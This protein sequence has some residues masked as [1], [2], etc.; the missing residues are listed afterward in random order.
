RARSVARGRVGP[1][2]RRPALGRERPRRRARA[3]AGGGRK[4]RYHG[5]VLLPAMHAGFSPA[6]TLRAAAS[7]VA[8]VIAITGAPCVLA[9][10]G[11]RDREARQHSRTRH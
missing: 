10:L 8:P 5:L 6:I 7:S 4:P 3:P 1:R 2:P 9:S 11:A